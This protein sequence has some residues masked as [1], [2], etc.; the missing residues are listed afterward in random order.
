MKELYDNIYPEDTYV[1]DNDESFY[2]WL[3]NKDAPADEGKINA[4]IDSI[5]IN[6][7]IDFHKLN[8]NDRE[9]AFDGMKERLNEL[10][11]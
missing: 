9:K 2:E 10:I 1:E 3:R 5:Q 7:V 8:R 11:C 6:S 4:F